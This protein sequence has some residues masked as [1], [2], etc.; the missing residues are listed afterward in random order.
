MQNIKSIIRLGLLESPEYGKYL[1]VMQLRDDLRKKKVDKVTMDRLSVDYK[2][3]KADKCCIIAPKLYEQYQKFFPE[4]GALL[5]YS[6]N[7]IIISEKRFDKEYQKF[8]EPLKEIIASPEFVREFNI[9]QFY[10]IW[11]S[12]AQGSIPKWEMDS[13]TYYSDKHELDGVNT[14]MYD[15]S[16]YFEIDPTPEIIETYTRGNREYQKNRIF[17]L[18]GTV[19][20]RNKDKHTFSLL[21]PDGVVTCKTYAGAF[22]HY[23]KAITRKGAGG[24]K[25]TIEKSWFTRGN[26]LMVKGFRRE[27]QFVL[28]TNAVK[29]QEKEHTIKLI[30]GVEENGELILQNER[31]QV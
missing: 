9:A 2:L 19:L 12:V 25:E 26:L 27:D 22:S 4:N 18:I 1:E 7:G 15:I 28:R 23:D 31:A 21:T 6:A 20:D 3:T 11:D 17:T 5:E 16:N 10:E 8:I 14:K 29:G 24:K 13:V 30:W